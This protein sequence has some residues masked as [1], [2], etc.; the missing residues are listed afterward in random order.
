LS[1]ET[2]LRAKKASTHRLVQF[3]IADGPGFRSALN[4]PRQLRFQ[5]P[6]ATSHVMRW[7]DRREKIFLGDVDRHDLIK[8]L[9]EA[10]QKTG[11]Q[12]HA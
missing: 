12:V 4:M 3:W 6:G 10:C 5:Y 9:A 1:L 11:W 7:G 8:T 2:E